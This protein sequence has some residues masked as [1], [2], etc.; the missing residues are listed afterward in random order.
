MK[1]NLFGFNTFRLPDPIYDVVLRIAHEI[2]TNHNYESAAKI[3]LEN[4]ITLQQ[5]LVKTL[6]LDIFDIA[7]LADAMKKMKTK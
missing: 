5:I 1:N 2:R 3:A 7:K 4:N 6:K